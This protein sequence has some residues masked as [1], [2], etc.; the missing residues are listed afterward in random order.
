M[1]TCGIC[2]EEFSIENIVKPCKESNKHI[3]CKTCFEEWISTFQE[4]NN[5]NENDNYYFLGND[6]NSS[7]P[8]SCPVCRG[9][10]II[11]N[12]NCEIYDDI[13]NMISIKDYVNNKSS[14]HFFVKKYYI[15]KNNTRKIKYEFYMAP[16][17]IKDQLHYSKTLLETSQT[18]SNIHPHIQFSLNIFD[19]PYIILHGL[20]IEYY[21][22]G[23]IKMRKNMNSNYHHGLYETFYENGN[24]EIICN[25]DYN[26]LHGSYILYHENGMIHVKTNFDNDYVIGNYESYYDDGF[27]ETQAFYIIDYNRKNNLA[28][29]V[30]NIKNINVS[31]FNHSFSDGLFIR[32]DKNETFNNNLIRNNMI[33]NKYYLSIYSFN[34]D[35]KPIKKY[36]FS[37]STLYNKP[38]LRYCVTYNKDNGLYHRIDYEHNNLITCDYTF[39]YDEKNDKEIYHDVYTKYEI[40]AKKVVKKD[41]K[42]Y[43]N[44][45]FC[46]EKMYDDED[47]LIYIKT[48]DH[49]K[50]L[51]HI[52][53]YVKNNIV[54][55][56]DCK[57]KFNKMN[58]TYYETTD[59]VN[60]EKKY[61]NNGLLSYIKHHYTNFYVLKN[62]IH[63]KDNNK[64]YLK[65]IKFTSKNDL[66]II[67]YF[68]YKN[69]IECEELIH[70]NKTI[71]R[72]YYYE[73]KNIKSI[74]YFERLTF[75]FL[76]NQIYNFENNGF[77]IQ[78]IRNYDENGKF[79]NISYEINNKKI[80]NE[81]ILNKRYI[82][83]DLHQNSNITHKVSF[84][85]NKL[86][87]KCITYMMNKKVCVSIFKN[88]K[89]HGKCKS[90]IY[91]KHKKI[92]RSITIYEDGFKNGISKSYF[93]N[94]KIHIKSCYKNNLLHNKYI[95]FNKEN[96]LIKEEYY[97]NNL[98]HGVSK[99]YNHYG[100][101]ISN[102]VHGK[103]HG[104]TQFIGKKENEVIIE[105]KYF[106]N[107]IPI[108]THVI[109]D[110]QN[111]IIYATCVYTTNEEEIGKY[112][113][114]EQ[115][116][117][118]KYIYSIVTKNQTYGNLK[119]TFLRLISKN[120][121]N[122]TFIHGLV[123]IYNNENNQII[124]E[125]NYDMNSLSGSYDIYDK[126]RN[127]IISTY[128]E[129]DNVVKYFYYYENNKNLILSFTN[130]DDLVEIN[131]YIDINNCIFFNNYE[132]SYIHT[133]V[134]KSFL[135]PFNKCEEIYYYDP[136]QYNNYDNNY[137]NYYDDQDYYDDHSY[138][139]S[140]NDSYGYD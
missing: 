38:Y 21:E 47:N 108:G 41:M 73:N 71:Y 78:H 64:S 27:L 87:V 33:Y 92:K 111:N 96:K 15:S 40:S 23:N 10:V 83:P 22:N 113:D 107:S 90:Y 130:K 56:Y 122:D 54:H 11:S 28:S 48:Y 94:G 131:K 61:N 34:K 79:L 139:Y 37:Y 115:I 39:Y 49:N 84:R 85:N 68:D 29:V 18:Y 52:E 24:P 101:S 86:H 99:N 51:A 138:G 35:T 60:I 105:T 114:I 16:F 106:E 132:Y 91:D 12:N 20:F 44:G 58:N 74:H 135:L 75:N 55:I 45:K 7:N 32:Y 63:N 67:T 112:L 102:Y 14:T 76:L 137:D 140:D 43:N 88:N 25:Y 46:E 66:K 9:K 19:K 116:D 6:E 70:D 2:L 26:K 13:G 72:K 136:D 117:F 3:F 97:E 50:M 57:L 36:Y 121:H 42:V 82:V 110:I 89:L 119:I 128:V 98:L 120:N 109:E 95:E 31:S 65:S 5:Q 77:N 80:G 123:S 69:I 133:S 127:K 93:D 53:S 8:P 62:Y 129:N 124:A 104:K 1:E 59:F 30:V 17:S 126:N 118:D 125:I 4:Q 100:V 81:H 134:D 103:L